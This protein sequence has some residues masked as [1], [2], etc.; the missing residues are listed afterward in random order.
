MEENQETAGGGEEA[1]DATDAS[2]SYEP[3]A[4]LDDGTLKPGFGTLMVRA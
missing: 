2:N 4:Q 1:L 3:E